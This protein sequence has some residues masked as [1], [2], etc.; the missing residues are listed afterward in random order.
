M[1]QLYL[2]RHTMTKRVTLGLLVLN[3]EP[4]ACTLEEP[5]QNNKPQISCIP[6]GTYDCIPHSGAR[7]KNVWRLEDVPNR[8]DV[9]IH[10]G[11]TLDHTEGC[12]LVGSN[13]G[14][15]LGQPAVL[16]SKVTLNKLREIL[17]KEFRLT[18]KNLKG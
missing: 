7:F 14:E 8:S 16:N 18:I 17:P 6:E 11:N 5:W 12:I 1:T 3:G 13:I 4:L 15:I 10:N 9:L 2:Y